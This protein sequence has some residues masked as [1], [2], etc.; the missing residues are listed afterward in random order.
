[1]A[2]VLMRLAAAE[3]AAALTLKAARACIVV[4]VVA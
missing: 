4:R 3:K 2:G 1:M